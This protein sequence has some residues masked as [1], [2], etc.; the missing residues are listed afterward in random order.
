MLPEIYWMA[1]KNVAEIIPFLN[2]IFHFC[3]RRLFARGEEQEYSGGY[4]SARI[5]E[6]CARQLKNCTG[7]ILDVGAG[8]GLVHDALR[9]EGCTAEITGL[10][11]WQRM[12]SRHRERIQPPAD[13]VQGNGL[14]L[15]FH[16]GV[17]SGVTC[18][19][20]LLNLADPQD[21]DQVIAE[22]LR[23]L[24]PGG[25][26]VFDLRNRRNLLHRLR[27]R[28]ARYYDETL[29]TPL[30]TDSPARVERLLTGSGR[31]SFER[32]GIGFPAKSPWAPIFLY[33]V[34]RIEDSTP[35]KSTAKAWRLVPPVSA[36]VT[37]ADGL[38]LALQGPLARSRGEMA[39]GRYF[40][41]PVR[42]VGSGQ[43][44]LLLILQ[45]LKEEYPDR[46]RVL[47]PAYTAPS[48]HVTIRTAGLIP[49]PVDVNPG[50]LDFSPSA[51]SNNLSEEIPLAV[52]RVHPFGVA[53]PV[54]PLMTHPQIQNNGVVV[55][56]DAAQSLG[57]GVGTR[58]A[59]T[60]SGLGFGSLNRGKNLPVDG[61]AL[62]FCSDQAR[63]Q[64]L[65]RLIT[66]L[67]PA[68]VSRQKFLP[69]TTILYALATRPLFYGM[70]QTLIR[71]HKQTTPP[72]GVDCC[73]FSDWQTRLLL[74]LL[75]RLEDW[76]NR[77][78]IHARRYQQELA[79][80]PE[81]LFLDVSADCLPAWNRFPVRVKNPLIRDRLILKL[82]DA[83][84]ELSRLYLRSIPD[85]FPQEVPPGEF[86]GAR[87]FAAELLTLPVQPDLLA[88]DQQKI[89]QRIRSILQD[90]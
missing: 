44:A 53:L 13:L 66:R 21:A 23:V 2:R 41:H 70:A 34:T 73:G 54:E 16:D 31:Y 77:R 45:L 29:Q 72:S 85:H 56:E 80:L 18:V 64:R 36:P 33:S 84:V 32:Q 89:I 17:F 28:M 75:P 68:P 3:R 67:P 24:R 61:G 86:S 7:S 79:G 6:E 71:R 43:V 62:L 78:R 50:N 76:N 46:R 59:G 10:E 87:Q 81:I 22:C 20:L 74:R 27:Y 58:F 9:R 25:T 88:R 4:Y 39:A 38:K 35:V 55:I 8:E 14:R 52:I 26:L 82:A 65:D 37:P 1:G 48:V 15:P 40:H 30:R 69:V 42:L 49:W 83:G 5:R 11:P 60:V 19:N 90:E 47:F 57:A 12:L 63:L 51:L